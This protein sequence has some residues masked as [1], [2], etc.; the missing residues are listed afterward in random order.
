MENGGV[1]GVCSSFLTLSK[2]WET[3]FFPWQVGSQRGPRAARSR[4]GTKV[5]GPGDFVG[6]AGERVRPA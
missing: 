4:P 2:R 5:Q 3:T 1:K 6:A